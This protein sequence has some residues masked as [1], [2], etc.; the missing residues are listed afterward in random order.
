MFTKTKSA[1]ALA[2]VL[3]AAPAALANELCMLKT[4]KH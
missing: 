4:R 1:L 2:L 3:G